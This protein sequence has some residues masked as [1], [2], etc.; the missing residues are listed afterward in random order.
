LTR[1]EPALEA[2]TLWGRANAAT[3]RARTRAALHSVR[4]ANELIEHDGVR[5][6]VRALSSLARNEDARQ[7]L[8]NLEA[9]MNAE[10][11]PFL[12]F[13]RD[14]Y[15]ADI[16][17][18]HVCLLNKFNVIDHHLLIVTREFEEQE[19][20]LNRDDFEALWTC[21]AEFDGLAFYNGGGVAGASQRHKHLQM[22]PLP[23][24]PTGPKVPVDP[25][26]GQAVFNGPTGV[27]P[28][29][30]FVHSIARVE[31]QW[32]QS[33]AQAAAATL[34]LYRTMLA[35][36]SLPVERTG[37]DGIQLGPYN[38]LISREWMLLLPRSAESHRTIAVNSLGFAGSMFVRDE[39]QLEI[40]RALGP[41]TILRNVAVE[42][43]RPPDST[44]A[45][46]LT[47]AAEHQARNVGT[48]RCPLQ[49]KRPGLVAR[50]AMS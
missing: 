39:Q 43:R 16:S 32:T 8:R 22:V 36:V 42:P 5:F 23:L 29:F 14:L 40:L 12:P 13:D 49:S 4:T 19:R 45:R 48:R 25:V 46:L 10:A 2:G 17:A 6:V 34:E 3:Q 35:D 41:M 44:A 30:S 7:A 9:A 1:G 50:S 47:F 33:P 18:T 20:L 24:V 37:T 28:G 31:P 15:V 38:L 27:A 21:M 26:I 11:D